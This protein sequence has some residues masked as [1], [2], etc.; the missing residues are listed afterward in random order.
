MTVGAVARLENRQRNPGLIAAPRSSHSFAISSS[1]STVRL[2]V[3]E[4][5]RRLHRS[6]LASRVAILSCN[7]SRQGGG[8]DMLSEHADKRLRSSGLTALWQGIADAATRLLGR[9]ERC[10]WVLAF[11]PA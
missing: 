1:R 11:C 6:A 5:A 10:A 3:I 2:S 8:S 7:F 4:A 9:I